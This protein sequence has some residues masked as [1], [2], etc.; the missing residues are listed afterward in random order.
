MDRSTE[1]GEATG[2]FHP[3]GD[4]A[5]AHLW[6]LG[7]MGKGYS[8]FYYV[9]DTLFLIASL[10][11]QYNRPYY[12]TESVRL[13]NGDVEV[14]DP[15]KTTVSERRTYFMDGR[16]FYREERVEAKDGRITFASDSVEIALAGELHRSLRAEY[17][18]RTPWP[19]EAMGHE[20]PETDNHSCAM[21][22]PD[23]ALA[24]VVLLNAQS[25]V[26]VVGELPQEAFIEWGEGIPHVNLRSVDGSQFLSLFF[27]YGGV[28]NEFSE[29]RVTRSAP[30]T[31]WTMLAIP[32]FRSGSGI[33]LG[34]TE[35]EVVAVLGECFRSGEAA[36]GHRLLRY[37]ITDYKES[38]FLQRYRYPSYYATLEFADDQLIEYRFGFGYP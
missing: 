20:R 1:G 10:S 31:V 12:W 9:N 13:E 7:E 32:D 26:A 17:A 18:K 11:F 25:T 21:I 28:R 19:T 36:N 14:F 29:L 22:R 34:M 27:H 30:D 4:L 23:S 38:T 3:S 16:P 24:G 35:H 6:L 37:H 2:Y 15:S 8:S 33:T 5:V